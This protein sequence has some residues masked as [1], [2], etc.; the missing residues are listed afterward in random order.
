[1]PA[2]AGACLTGL[3]TVAVL[4]PGLGFAAFWLAFQSLLAVGR[5]GGFGLGLLIAAAT[6]LTGLSVGLAALAALRVAATAL[7]GRPRTPRAAAADE[8]PAAVR[9]FLLGLAMLVVLLGV[10][11]GLALLPAFGWARG[12]AAVS[13]LGLRIGFDTPAYASVFV[14][15]L[16]AVAWIGLSRL[17][18]HLP[19]PRREPAWSGGFAAPPP[20]MPFGDPATQYGPSSFAAPLHR[21]LAVLLPAA[22]AGRRRLVHWR[23]VLLR[24]I[25]ALVAT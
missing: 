9:R 15:A 6:I 16:V 7:L 14:A 3:F 1:M 24:A 25:A 20:W 10:A 17:L 23:D 13:P 18:R 22:K 8:A 21:V 11:P 19:A 2:T 5:I 4:P 12:A